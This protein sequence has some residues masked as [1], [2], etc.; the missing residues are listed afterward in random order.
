MS[1]TIV[2]LGVGAAIGYGASRIMD[3]TTGWY[4]ERQS[5]TS[6]RREEEI[7]PGGAPVLA[8]K[9]IASMVG[10]EVADEEAARIG[11]FVHRSLGVSYGMAATALV[12]A[13]MRPM[14]AG[15]TTGAAA[16]LLVDEVVNS[17]MFTPPPQAYPVESHL[18]GVV[19]HLAYGIVAGSGLTIVRRLGAI[20]A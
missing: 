7:A 15:I 13:G 6:R 1:N 20:R 5:E 9:K 3:R 18:R 16:F 17:V 2:D 14:R 12:R 19:G 4:F 8:G 10:R 11:L